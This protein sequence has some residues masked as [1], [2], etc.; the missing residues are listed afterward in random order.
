MRKLGKKYVEASKKVDRATLYT[1]EEAI[2]LVKETATTKFDSTVEVAFN[3]NLDTKKADQQLRGSMVLPNGTG[4][5]KR[6]LVIAK[7][8]AAEAARA[9]GADYVGDVD[10]IDKIANENWFDY[11][12]IVATPDMM[13]QL[14]KI[15]RVLGPKGLMPNPKTGTVTMDTTKAVTDIK[16][17]MVEYKTDS[18][19]NVHTVIGKVSFDDAKLLEN[20]N[21][22]VS[23]IAKSKPT[24]VKGK[25]I[26]NI[27]ISS[28]MGPGIKLDQNSFDI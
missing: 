26:L 17:G 20:L 6:V 3:L 21:Y 19:G 18:Y 15:G 7:G 23:T 12:V 24:A 1:A 9:A 28:T 22:V 11:D 16:K 27:S 5:T 2:K 8:E 10:M 14:G 4:K 25:Y 13:A